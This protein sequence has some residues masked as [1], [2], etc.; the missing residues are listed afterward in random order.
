MLVGLL[1]FFASLMIL[2]GGS[3]SRAKGAFDGGVATELGEAEPSVQRANTEGEYS[4]V[5]VMLCLNA[6]FFYV[7]GGSAA[8]AAVVE[9]SPLVDHTLS[10]PTYLPF[11]FLPIPM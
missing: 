2:Q 10:L 6:V 9:A 5:D 8:A 1:C 7:D 3:A 11:L 4:F